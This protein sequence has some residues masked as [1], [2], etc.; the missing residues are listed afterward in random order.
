MRVSDL[1]PGDVLLQYFNSKDA[2]DWVIAG[3]QGAFSHNFSGGHAN[4]IHAL[5][6]IGEG[7]TAESSPSKHADGLT[8]GEGLFT[9]ELGEGEIAKA[10]FDVWRFN[11]D[12]VR[13]GAAEIAKA[14]LLRRAALLGDTFGKTKFG[15]YGMKGAVV[16]FFR[17]K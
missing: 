3:A 8:G 1:E 13:F 6:H 9:Q 14:F 7:M 4:R 17:T 12:A 11:D 16:K 15:R 10:R 5:M 2:F